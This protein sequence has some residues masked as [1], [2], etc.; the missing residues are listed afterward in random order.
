M[1]GV[2][3]GPAWIGMWQTIYQ[4]HFDFLNF[5]LIDLFQNFALAKLYY[6]QYPSA[7]VRYHLIALLY[8]LA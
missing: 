5:L 7:I 1:T 8:L 3:S 4:K 2:A 6:P